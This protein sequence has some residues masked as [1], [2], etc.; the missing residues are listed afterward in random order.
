MSEAQKR[1]IS[2]RRWLL[3]HALVAL[4][5]AVLVYLVILN[6]RYAATDQLL[7][8]TAPEHVLIA[9]GVPS[10]F[11]LWGWMLTDF[12]RSKTESKSVAWGW[13]LVLGN[14]LAALVYFFVIWRPRHART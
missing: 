5:L 11:W 9:A 3:A 13:F 4:S 6:F 12:F 10:M 8:P 14:W 1:T 7:Q 2:T